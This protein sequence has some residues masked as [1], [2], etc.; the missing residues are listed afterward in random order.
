[1]G[2]VTCGKCGKEID[3]QKEGTVCDVCDKMLC[4]EHIE[5]FACDRSNY[6]WQNICAE[7]FSKHKK[8]GEKK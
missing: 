4:D 5:W 6:P 2:K 8:A 1:M 7:C 3:P